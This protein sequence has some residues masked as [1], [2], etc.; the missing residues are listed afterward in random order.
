MDDIADAADDDPRVRFAGV[1]EPKM[2]WLLVI[3]FEGFASLNDDNDDC[4][5]LTPSAVVP[6]GCNVAQPPASP[7]ANNVLVV[8]M[9]VVV[10][11]SAAFVFVFAFVFVSSDACGDRSGTTEVT[12]S[13]GMTEITWP[14]MSAMMK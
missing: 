5:E 4:S 11:L 6:C 14:G 3:D 1:A 8:A 13:S 12:C 9:G 2:D 7:G 10:A